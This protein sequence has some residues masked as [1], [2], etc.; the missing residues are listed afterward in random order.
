M[1]TWAGV[2]FLESEQAWVP[3]RDCPGAEGAGEGLPGKQPPTHS[4]TPWTWNPCSPLHEPT[5]SRSRG[6]SC[7]RANPG[8]PKGWWRL[9]AGRALQSALGTMSPGDRVPPP[10]ASFLR[11]TP[12][13]GQLLLQSGVAILEICPGIKAQREGRRHSLGCIHPN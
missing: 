8:A 2:T 1:A 5:V 12:L 7:S 4:P 9:R 13:R 10:P 6:P 11:V 3:R